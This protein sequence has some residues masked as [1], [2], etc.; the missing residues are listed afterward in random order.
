M[1]SD[2]TVD[3]IYVQED[4]CILLN[5]EVALTQISQ[6]INSASGKLLVCVHPNFYIRYLPWQISDID[7][8]N[9]YTYTIYLEKLN[10]LVNCFTSAGIPILFLVE[11]RDTTGKFEENYNKCIASFNKQMNIYINN[12]PRIKKYFALTKLNT[13]KLTKDFTNS[14]GRQL[15]LDQLD[16]LF[17]YLKKAGLSTAYISG[18]RFSST[19]GSIELGKYNALV[20]RP[21]VIDTFSFV[22]CVPSTVESLQRIG[23][24]VAYT[25][26]TYPTT[27]PKW[28]DLQKTNDS[29]VASTRHRF[30]DKRVVEASS[31]SMLE[32]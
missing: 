26:V 4:H 23:I 7:G 8:R 13:P 19:W 29:K 21:R 27:V 24:R 25:N 10:K 6:D 9:T 14:F 2:T 11:T 1:N 3:K 20:L 30:I 28:F 17:S 22:G 15:A 32:F 16:N 31:Q 12:Y 18:V 5:T